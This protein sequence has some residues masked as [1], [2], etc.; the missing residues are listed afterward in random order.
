[1]RNLFLTAFVL[2]FCSAC[3]STKN[4]PLDINSFEK[5]EF[6]KISLSKRE[7]PDFSATTPGKAAFGGFGALAMISAGNK[8]IEENNIADPANFISAELGKTLAEKYGSVEVLRSDKVVSGL[9]TQSVIDTYSDVGILLDV[10]TIN[11][12]FLYFPTKW[13]KYRVI[14]SA[15]LRLVDSGSGKLL[16]EGF[17]QRTPEYD[18]NAPTKEQLLTDSAARLKEELLLG[19]KSCIEQLKMNVLRL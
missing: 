16:A 8:I 3:V 1:M 6:S 13:G 7:K 14:Y 2:A 15:K 18:D 4:V 9:K 12:S 5:I 10:Q 17:C 19:A 11:W